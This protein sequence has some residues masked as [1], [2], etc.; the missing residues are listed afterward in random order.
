MLNFLRI[1]TVG[2]GAISVLMFMPAN[3]SS[4]Q[5]IY[6]SETGNPGSTGHALTV[7]VSKLYKRELGIDIQINDSQTLTKS[8]LK[9]GRGKL[10]L[11]AVPTSVYRFLST[12]SRMYKKK[13]HKQA[14]KASKNV[15]SLFGFQAVVFHPVTF[16]IDGIKTWNDIKGKSVFTGPPSGGAAVTAESMIRA[17]TGF[18]P[19]KDYKAVHLNWGSGLQA[20][21]D[22]KL[23]VFMRPVNP[24]AAMIEQLGLSKKFRLLDAGTST[25]SDGWKKW[26]KRP[27]TGT[28][29]IR[30]GTYSGQVN[31]DRDVIVGSNTFQWAVRADI[32]NDLAYKM[33]KIIWDNLAEIHK[34]SVILKPITLKDPFTGANAKMHAGAIKYYK[35]KGINIPANLTK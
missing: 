13:L 8:A 16:D 9:L 7:V 30:A 6:K 19:N 21:M 23:D 4:A 1:F 20:M 24:G 15:R 3:S 17:L 18:E 26:L 35:E 32:S 27:G 22:G 28:G 2:L 31:N 33:T 34:T 12:G 5:T 11:L 25:N 10:D 14:I 29:V